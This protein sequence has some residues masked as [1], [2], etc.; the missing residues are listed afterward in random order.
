MVVK[1]LFNYAGGKAFMIDD[2]MTQFNS[3]AGKVHRVIDVFGGSG[4][5]MLNV[6]RANIENGDYLKV[7]NDIDKGMVNLF[8]VLRDDK[9]RDAL[10]DKF[11]YY[12]QSREMTEC[13]CRHPYDEDRIEFAY[14]MIYALMNTFDSRLDTC[15]YSYSFDK[16]RGPELTINR[17]KSLA[18]ELRNWNIENLYFKDLI[19]KYDSDDAFF[20][21]DPPYHDIF[22]YRNNMSDMSWRM[23]RQVLPSIN[24]KWLMNINDNPTVRSLFGQP[25]V[26][27]EY[28]NSMTNTN[29]ADKTKRVEL[30]YANFDLVPLA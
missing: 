13:Y 1:T 9:D 23:L 2:I 11:S 7:Y 27:K 5:F 24:G 4:K 28:D 20:Y 19:Q 26:Y 10:L 30:Y 21:L 22:I 17:I 3:V 16:N 18:Y 12:I 14:K 25:K 8:S 15:T 29:V 6:P